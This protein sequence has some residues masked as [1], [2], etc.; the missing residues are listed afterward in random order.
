MF[1][2]PH[3][4]FYSL[5]SSSLSLISPCLLCVR[6]LSYLSTRLSLHTYILS[7]TL[8]HSPSFSHFFHFHS[9]S[10]TFSHFV[11]LALSYFLPH[12]LTLISLLLSCLL[13]PLSSLS[14]PLFIS[15]LYLLSCRSKMIDVAGPHREVP[16]QS[17][18]PPLLLPSSPSSSSHLLKR[19]I[20]HFI[21]HHTVLC[22]V[23]SG[24]LCVF[25][26]TCVVCSWCVCLFRC[27]WVCVGV[28]F[29]LCGLAF[30]SACV[31]VFAVFLCVFLCGV[32]VYAF[33]RVFALVYVCCEM[34]VHTTKQNTHTRPHTQHTTLTRTRTRD[35]THTTQDD[36]L[37]T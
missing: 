34:R 35:S 32:L 4:L 8:S 23:E 33:T 30:W 5:S 28:S 15:S 20:N 2:L 29:C 36:T 1:G 18:L 21:S 16:L 6:R 26:I 25:M 31:I 19:R 11:S 13:Y 24:C 7:L 14:S 37:A 22:A 27:V 10:L 9:L 17:L 12:S 3:C